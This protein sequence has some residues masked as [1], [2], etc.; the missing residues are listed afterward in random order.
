M[1]F[2][3]HAKIIRLILVQD[4]GRSSLANPPI[5]VELWKAQGKK[6]KP[7]EHRDANGPSTPSTLPAGTQP[8]MPPVPYPTFPPVGY[9][10]INYPPVSYPPVGYPPYPS[11]YLMYPPMGVASHYPPHPPPADRQSSPPPADGMNIIDFCGEYKLG[12]EVLEGLTALKF[13][14]GDDHREIT[15]EMLLEVKF[16]PHHWKRFCKAYSR[17]K[18]VGK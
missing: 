17:Y 13:Q 16:A 8:L 11:P 12:G 18:H 7:A 6:V 4:N 1:W 3:L 9:P 10:P 2:P 15:P 5:E 14:I